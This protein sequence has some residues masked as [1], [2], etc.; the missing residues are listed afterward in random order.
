MSME[1]S[2]TKTINEKNLHFTN[3]FILR[4]SF[5]KKFFK[6]IDQRKFLGLEH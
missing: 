6:N 5:M 1:K 4:I 2:P 3:D